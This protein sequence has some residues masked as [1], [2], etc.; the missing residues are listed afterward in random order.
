MTRLGVLCAIIVFTI[1]PFTFLSNSVLAADGTLT[2]QK[3]EQ[4]VLQFFKDHQVEKVEVVGVL[5]L[6]QQNAAQ[7]DLVIT[8][9][10][11]ARPKNDAVTAYAFG[12]GGGTFLWSGRGKAIFMHYNDGRW[13][14]NQLITEVATVDNLNIVVGSPVKRSVQPRP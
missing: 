6:P 1:S 9:M 12:Q 5:E 10:L 7:A 2:N 4:A 13:V 8:N 3:A 11:V 14:F